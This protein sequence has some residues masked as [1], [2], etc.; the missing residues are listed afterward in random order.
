MKEKN[1]QGWNIINECLNIIAMILIAIVAIFGIGLLFAIVEAHAWI[2]WAIVGTCGIWIF[3]HFI[4]KITDKI[5]IWW[6]SIEIMMIALLA[7]SFMVNP[8]VL[9]PT[10]ICVVASFILGMEIRRRRIKWIVGSF[11]LPLFLFEKSKTVFFWFSRKEDSS[12]WI[13]IDFW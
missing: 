1:L 4:I 5:V 7:I 3:L 12:D 9:L 10:I 11:I 13:N 6:I 2:P 8:G